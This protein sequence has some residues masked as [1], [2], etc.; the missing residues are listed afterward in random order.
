MDSFS[1]T[2]SDGFLLAFL[3]SI[4]FFGVHAVQMLDWDDWLVSLEL[5]VVFLITAISFTYCA[6][7]NANVSVYYDH[8]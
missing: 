6:R 1:E 4:P 7:A 3:A 5:S 2:F 8:S